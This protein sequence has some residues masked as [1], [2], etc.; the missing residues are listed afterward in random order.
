MLAS[1]LAMPL[2]MALGIMGLR[3][4]QWIAVFAGVLVVGPILMKML[5][6]N[7]FAGFRIEARRAGR[8]AASLAPELQ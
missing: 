5:I 4:S 7:Q 2:N 8:T 6:G 1:V 3:V